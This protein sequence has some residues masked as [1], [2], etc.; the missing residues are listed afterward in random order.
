M[1][2]PLWDFDESEREPTMIDPLPPALPE[3]PPGELH[4]KPFVVGEGETPTERVGN[5]V[6]EAIG[7]LS[8]RV[9][10]GLR[11]MS[12]KSREAGEAIGSITD[13]AQERA[14]ELSQEAAI[15]VDEFRQNTYR[16]IRQARAAGRRAVNEHP[17]ESL[18]A[19]GGMALMVGCLLRIWRSNGD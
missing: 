18:V 10:S 9:R 11:A 17:L 14:R 16:R 2:E 7:N 6:G 4:Q 12:G 5:A 1:A 15:R 19:I 3:T 13:T 8:S